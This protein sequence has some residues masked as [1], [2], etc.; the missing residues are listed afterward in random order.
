MASSDERTA[1]RR[2]RRREHQLR[3]RLRAAAR[4][5]ED[6]E[7]AAQATGAWA[8]ACEAREL[9]DS[10]RAELARLAVD[11]TRRDQRD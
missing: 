9:Q 7:V 10:A 4:W 3:V 5:L 8:L 2:A 11:R 6:L 1:R